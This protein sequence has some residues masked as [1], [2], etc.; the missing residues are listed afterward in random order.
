[1]SCVSDLDH[2]GDGMDAAH[3]LDDALSQ[4]GHTE[5]DGPVSV[6]LQLDHL[7]GTGNKATHAQH[8]YS[9][10]LKTVRSD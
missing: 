10:P 5:A 6:A 9:N 8:L 4:V 1:M 2:G 7:V 3:V